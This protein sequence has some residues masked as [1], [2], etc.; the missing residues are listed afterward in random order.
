MPTAVDNSLVVFGS[1][2]FSV[3]K[4]PDEEIQDFLRQY[5]PEFLSNRML[6]DTSFSPGAS[7]TG[8]EERHSQSATMSGELFRGSSDVSEADSTTI[9]I[10]SPDFLPGSIAQSLT[11]PQQ[12]LWS[13]YR[14][15]II[16]PE[17]SMN[18]GTRDGKSMIA[19]DRT[20]IEF[21]S[22]NQSEAPAF[23]DIGAL[24][25]PTIR[26]MHVPY[27]STSETNSRVNVPV[28]EPPL[29]KSQ[30]SSGSCCQY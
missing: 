13:S 14:A 28:S 23:V 21:L 20:D 10:P 4:N 5:A 7:I 19:L 6:R 18:H 24:I 15:G 16:E 26:S 3:I 11:L 25:S 30:R 12:G 27:T 29:Q 2:E 22:W 17:D 1:P 9:A 8:D